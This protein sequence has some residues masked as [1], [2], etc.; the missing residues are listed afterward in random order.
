MMEPT[1]L[2]L[3][4]DIIRHTAVKNL[5]LREIILLSCSTRCIRSYIYDYEYFWWDIVR[6]ELTDDP[7]IFNRQYEDNEHPRDV[8]MY[9]FSFMMDQ[10]YTYAHR[11]D[12]ASRLEHAAK[13]GYEKY[14]SNHMTDLRF[15]NEGEEI[16][17][18]YKMSICSAERGYI[19]IFKT[20]TKPSE[21]FLYLHSGIQ[22]GNVTLVRYI[23]ETYQHINRGYLHDEYYLN[24]VQD[25]FIGNTFQTGDQTREQALEIA[26]YLLAN[27]ATINGSVDHDDHDCTAMEYALLV[28]VETIKY[29][30]QRGARIPENAL[31]SV[32]EHSCRSE[33]ERDEIIHFLTTE[34]G[35]RMPARGRLD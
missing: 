32:L 30:L 10:E 28:D 11:P 14:V 8:I 16:N 25:A 19:D 18:R 35:F 23:V 24:E 20:V 22:S 4:S 15:L 7:V 3:P 21:V 26:D 13:Q 2:S 5:S 29:L 17:C 6:R 12:R 27:G 9:L 31:A 1:L 33:D 34:H